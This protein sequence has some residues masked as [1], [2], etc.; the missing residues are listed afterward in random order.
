VNGDP[1]VKAQ[2]AVDRCRLMLHAAVRAL[3]EAIAARD[4][5]SSVLAQGPSTPAPPNQ[6][7]DG[8]GSSSG[9]GQ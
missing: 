5:R 7:H 4:E 2:F 3:D 9:I 1:V 8:S 6:R